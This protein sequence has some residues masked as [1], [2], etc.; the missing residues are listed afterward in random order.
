MRL[1]LD[2]FELSCTLLFVK[3]ILGEVNRKHMWSARRSL[4]HVDV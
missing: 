4:L 1:S 2:Q 3:L